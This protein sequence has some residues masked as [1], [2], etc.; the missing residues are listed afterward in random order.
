MAT[1]FNSQLKQSFTLFEHHIFGRHPNATGT[2]LKN[3]DAS[4]MHAVILW[5][6]ERW[7]L[8]DSSANGTFVNGHK[9]SKCV[10]HRLNTGDTICFGSEQSE[11]WEIRDL[12]P[13]QT[14][15]VP[16]TE[17]LSPI[18]LVDI[19]GL[20]CDEKPEILLYAS[21][22]GQW[23]C[24]NQE[25]IASV[26]KSGDIV[27][28]PTQQWRFIESQGSAATR[29]THDGS[30]PPTGDIKFAFKASQN[31]EHVSLTLVIDNKHIDLGERS[32]HY[33]LLFLARQ[34]L[35]DKK[36]HLSEQEQGWI[37]KDVLKKMLGMPET[38]INI[39]VH[40]FRKQVTV[41]LPG[42]TTLHQIIERRHGEIRFAF[43]SIDIEG[44]LKSTA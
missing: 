34:R 25:G 7:S 31:E 20:P 43:D 33:L 41:A 35:N 21:P 14:R 1:L 16:L 19:A 28:T 3:R 44:G 11:H 26:L 6:G 40:R 37:K 10:N 17:G 30:P 2:Q 39:Q 23:M 13:P 24:E 42:T 15:L 38:H 36:L 18:D 4:R 5:D 32:H 9:I 29:A 22:H 12:H 27:G 8:K